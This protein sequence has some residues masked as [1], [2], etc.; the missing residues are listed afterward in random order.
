MKVIGS[1]TNSME[2]V[3]RPGPMEQG[4]RVS[5][6][7]A[8]STAWASSPGLMGALT[9]VHSRRITS[10]EMESTTGLTEESSRDLGTIIRWRVKEYSLGQTV[11]DMRETT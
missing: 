6:F 4:T 2:K 3:S 9:M 7:S 11:E 1:K 10:R 5:T 8:R